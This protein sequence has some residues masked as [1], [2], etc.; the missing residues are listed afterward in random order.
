[1]MGKVNMVLNVHR[2]TRRLIRVGDLELALLWTN[3]MM[4]SAGVCVCLVKDTEMIVFFSAID[5][6]LNQNV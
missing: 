3:L 2:I 1:M 6:I 5:S 4:K